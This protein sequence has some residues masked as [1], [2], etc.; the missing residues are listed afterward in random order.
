MFPHQSMNSGQIHPQTWATFSSN[1]R[2][3]DVEMQ[4]HGTSI[5]PLLQEKTFFFL[6]VQLVPSATLAPAA[7][8]AVFI[9]LIFFS[10]LFLSFLFFSSAAAVGLRPGV[11]RPRG[12]N[13]SQPL[14][15]ETKPSTFKS[16]TPAERSGLALKYGRAHLP[17]CSPPFPRQ[18]SSQDDLLFDA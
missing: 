5:L 3:A 9:S 2:S 16:E 14:C 17:A 11:M 7:D 15:L 4:I 6:G 10:F 18:Q 12:C 1:F 8:S 13:Q